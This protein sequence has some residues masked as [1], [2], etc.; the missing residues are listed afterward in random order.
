M[1]ISFFVRET[2]F[3]IG[4]IGTPSFLY[5]SILSIARGQKC[6]G[7]HRKIINT[8]ISGNSDISLVTAVHPIN[9]GSAPDSPPMTIFCGVVHFR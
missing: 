5:S 7:V 8:K 9:G 4:I 6:G 1:T 2:P 3:A